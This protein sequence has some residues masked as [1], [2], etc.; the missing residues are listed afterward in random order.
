MVLKERAENYD[1]V[2]TSSMHLQQ[3]AAAAGAE[4]WFSKVLININH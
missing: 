1:A 2:R 3:Y 4:H